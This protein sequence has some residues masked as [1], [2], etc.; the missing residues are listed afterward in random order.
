VKTQLLNNLQNTK[1][2]ALP[3]LHFLKHVK[4][5]PLFASPTFMGRQTL[6]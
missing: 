4:L 3:T 6:F 2:S 5:I 1:Q